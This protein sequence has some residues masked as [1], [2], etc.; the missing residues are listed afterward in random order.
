M[1]STTKPDIKYNVAV[2]NCTK[3]TKKD[4]T[5]LTERVEQHLPIL[6]GMH[7][8]GIAFSLKGVEK[9]DK[10]ALEI[11]LEK[12]KLYHVKLN[13][14][15][16]L[17]DYPPKI[18]PVLEL[19]V[20]DSPLGLFRT[21][22]VMALALGT[23]N[24][25]NYASILVHTDNIDNRQ[26]I[27]STLISNNYFAVMATSK[28]DLKAR[29]A[30]KDK[31]GAII[32]H[33][34]FGN[35][36]ETFEV[37]FH[38]NIYTYELKGALKGN[39]KDRLNVEDFKYR[40][41]LKYRVFVLDFAKVYYMDATVAHLIM[42]LDALAL[43]HDA[44]ICVIN[45]DTDKI[46]RNALSVLQNSKLWVYENMDDVI[47]DDDITPLIKRT[48]TTYP[49]D[50]IPKRMLSFIPKLIGSTMRTMD[51]YTINDASKTPSKQTVL[52]EL[53]NLKPT[54][55][56]HIEFKGDA[57][58]DMIFLFAQ[59][60]TEVLL[61]H[62]LGTTMEAEGEDFLDA[63]SEFVNSVTGTLKSALKKE[64]QCIQFSLPKSTPLLSDVC[65]ESSK[66]IAVLTG[67]ECKEQPFYIA[68]TYPIL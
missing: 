28:E 25:G 61:E 22:D 26:T 17:I 33:S 60:S 9:V 39:I 53:I 59:G 49:Y 35:I 41:S 57:E 37:T 48:K 29:L 67:F 12:F 2:Y 4:V 27:A 15:A 46:E 23:S 63:M 8:K 3:F 31:F 1:H 43:E 34:F 30:Q 45:L 21:V 5:Q 52:S 10:E 54:I 66:Q 64:Y 19:F 6:R 24:I 36:F 55:V 40:L 62:I 68:I 56:T 13:A 18:F 14:M 42:E 7:V 50:G 65:N 38:N 20:R 11:V 44:H 47:T 51:I 58:G 32:T 16:G